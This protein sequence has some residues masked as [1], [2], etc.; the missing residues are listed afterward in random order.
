MERFVIQM[1][2]EQLEFRDY[3]LR[4]FPAVLAAVAREA[5]RW[6]DCGH[7]EEDDGIVLQPAILGRL[8]PAIRRMSVAERD[9]FAVG[10]CWVVQL[11]QRV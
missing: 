6:P 8:N 5:P 9:F 11:D 4:L 3:L 1:T 2:R 7:S 10:L